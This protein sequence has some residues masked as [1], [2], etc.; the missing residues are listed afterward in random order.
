M[1]SNFNSLKM[2]FFPEYKAFYFIWKTRFQAG[3]ICISSIQFEF[4]KFISILAISSSR[5]TLCGS[6]FIFFLL[7]IDIHIDLIIIYKG[8]TFK[9]N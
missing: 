4:L 1:V 3:K 8:L 7:I 9:K 6:I 2:L 5:N